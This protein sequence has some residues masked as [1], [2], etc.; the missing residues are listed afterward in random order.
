M[1]EELHPEEAE[2]PPEEEELHLVEGTFQA[3]SCEEVE[4]LSHRS[5]Y[6]S[7]NLTKTARGTWRWEWRSVCYSL[8][9]GSSRLS[10]T[11]GCW[12]SPSQYTLPT[13]RT[14]LLSLKP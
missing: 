14:C 11:N 4:T 6:I 10:S 7:M 3:T 9:V 8:I 1:V 2:L 13:S 12:C 5:Q